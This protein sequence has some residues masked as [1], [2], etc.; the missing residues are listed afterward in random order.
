MIDALMTAAIAALGSL[1]VGV[2]RCR[3]GPK[4]S[5]LYQSIALAMIGGVVGLI[6]TLPLGFL[7]GQVC[8]DVVGPTCSGGGTETF[9][10]AV[11]P[12]AASLVCAQVLSARY[13]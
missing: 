9:F 5:R 1:A 2:V 11:I 10:E 4:G 6:G 12:V 8:V 7:L 13:A 3:G